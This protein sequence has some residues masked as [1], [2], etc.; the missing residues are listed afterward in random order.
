VVDQWVTYDSLVRA[1]RGLIRGSALA[2]PLVVCAAATSLRQ[3]L[4]ATTVAPRDHRLAVLHHDG[5]VT[6]GEHVVD[7]D[8][9]GLP[10]DELTAVPVRR[11]REVV[12]HFVLVAAG[13]VAYPSTEERRLAI[14]L[15]DQVASA[16][17]ARTD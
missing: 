11:G 15:A 1:H 14:L 3:H 9:D 8:R 2:V 10:F 13:K 12:G 16:L 7:V 6:R 4:A 5:S 17:D